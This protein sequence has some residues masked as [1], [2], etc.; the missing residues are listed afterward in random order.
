VVVLALVALVA[1][2]A[3]AAE[4]TPEGARHEK[5]LELLELTG[6][7]G[8]A[9]QIVEGTVGPLRQA[10][11]DVP[12][13]LW[14]GFADGVDRQG[15]IDLVIP[16][17]DKHLTDPEID[18]LIGFY[19]TPEGQSVLSKLPIIGQESMM[20]GQMWSMQVA[21]DLMAALEASGHAVPPEFRQQMMAPR[22]TP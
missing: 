13:E 18:A 15:F 16:V 5:I 14:D 3:F 7:A 6:I 9:D 19:R 11:P 4:G 21:E 17:H 1:A 10:M 12:A 22:G 8:L 2:P 20:I